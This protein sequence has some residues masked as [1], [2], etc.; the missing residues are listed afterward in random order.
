VSERL[1][2]GIES[3][4][5]ETA[6]AIVDEHRRVRSS[7]VASQHDLHE[8][9]AGVVP[10]LAS[11]AHLERLVPVVRAACSEA[12]VRLHDLDAIAVGHAPGLIGSLLVG[13]SA[14]KALAWS[15]DKPLIGVH[16]VLAHVHAAALD[17]PEL[18]LPAVG[19]VASGGHT[20]VFKLSEHGE[21]RV[22]AWTIDDAVGEAF[23]KAGTMLRAGYPGGPAVE[24]LARGGDASVIDLPIGRPRDG[25]FSFSGLKTALLYAL[26]GQPRRVDGATVFPREL[27]DVEPQRRRDLAA[28]FQ[29]AAVAGLRRGLGVAMDDA[30]PVACLVAGGG[31]I[32]NAAVRAMLESVAMERSLP[33]RLPPELLCVDNAAMIAGLGVVDLCAGR[34]ADLSLQAMARAP[35]GAVS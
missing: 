11:R 31:V 32:A 7:V 16:H 2:L 28:A 24:R 18:E 1:V 22:L 17:A 35:L 3:S 5:D 21:A 4:C 27:D 8:Q 13:V 30:G 33:L 29:Q 34:A 12:G 15:L 9:Y 23:D 20:H 6:A 10:E 19:L 14:A 26:R 25:G